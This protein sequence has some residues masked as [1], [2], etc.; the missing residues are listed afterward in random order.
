MTQ[1]FNEA[2]PIR[3]RLPMYGISYIFKEVQ[4]TFKWRIK[5]EKRYILVF[6]LGVFCGLFS[7]GM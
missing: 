5:I 7:N 1:R 4:R 6:R 2:H 3:L